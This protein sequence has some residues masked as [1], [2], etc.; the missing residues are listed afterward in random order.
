MSS[1]NF[2]T[3]QV[4]TGSR[5]QC[6]AGTV[7]SMQWTLSV[8]TG[9]NDRRHV[10]VCVLSTGAGTVAVAARIDTNTK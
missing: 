8:V 10:D 2:L 5:E 7:L 6:L 9:S 3:N 4:G 1:A